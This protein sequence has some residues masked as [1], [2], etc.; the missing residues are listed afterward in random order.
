MRK[1]YPK[2]D[3]EFRGMHV[4]KKYIEKYKGVELQIQEVDVNHSF[5][6]T[7]LIETLLLFCPNVREVTIHTPLEDYDLEMILLYDKN[8]LL[9]QLAELKELALMHDLRINLL[10]HTSWE[11]ETHQKYTITLLQEVLSSIKGFPVYLMIENVYANL[12]KKCN[13]LRLC[14]FMGDSQLI[15]CLDLCHLYCLAHI[16][17]TDIDSFL[18][19]Y[20]T[21]EEC[22]KY[23]H[24]IHF[25]YTANED[26]YKDHKWT[27]SVMHPTISEM[28]RD[29]EFL[30]KY[31][32]YDKNFVT[33]I[34]EKD[35]NT[36]KDQIKEIDTLEDIYK[37]IK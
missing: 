28:V 37:M 11:L 31:G 18:D 19:T 7:D 5:L 25:S 9:N 30:Y 22:S 21:K 27:H 1:I 8:I 36:R 13:I 32:M 23:I 6:C 4:L 10:Y 24:Q 34:R 29:V 26:G 33:E 20:L 17:K 35:Y 12:E 15:G 2:I 16:Y 14:K 3:S